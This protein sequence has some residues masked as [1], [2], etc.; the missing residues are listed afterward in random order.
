M[1]SNLPIV[2]QLQADAVNLA[3]PVATTLRLAKV[4]ATKLDQT[5]A[6][7]WIDRE[8][9]GYADIPQD[10][11][12]TYRI[13]RGHPKGFNPI[14]GWQ[15]IILPCEDSAEHYST[16]VFIQPVAA[17]ENLIRR[18][19]GH[20]SE[21]MV[22]YP[23]EMGSTL[24][25]GIR[26]Q[27]DVAIFLD[28]SQLMSITETVRNLILNWSL[29]LEK[30]GI[31]G[32]EMTFTAA[33]KE[34]SGP[35]TQKFFIQN[36]GILGNVNDSAT[37]TNTQVVHA[38]IDLDVL[39]DFI[40]ETKAALAILPEAVRTELRPVIEGLEAES[41]QREPDSTKVRDYLQSVKAI[42]EGVAGNVA[43][44]GIVTLLTKLFAV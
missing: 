28:V 43:A 41:A 34:E 24:R 42:C 44:H 23:A 17:L 14:H 35:V 7:E 1:K 33:E 9:S 39:K 38:G 8:L 22:S 13:I 21:Y 40:N 12:P 11:V 3:I 37:I 25:E 20:D 6:L 10:E 27:T 19:D 29:E 31:L 30:A 32:E 26:I 16:A 18:K 5:T 4:I 2:R 36:V 15:R